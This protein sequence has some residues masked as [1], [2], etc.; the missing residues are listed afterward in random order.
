VYFDEKIAIMNDI[1]VMKILKIFF[2]ISYGFC[3]IELMLFVLAFFGG[4]EAILEA[5]EARI[6]EGRG[7]VYISS[8]YS[9]LS[10]VLSFLTMATPVLYL[11]SLLLCLMLPFFKC[12][13]SKLRYIVGIACQVIIIFLTVLTLL[14]FS[15]LT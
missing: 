4:A 6:P 5:I 14:L 3:L 8:E 12:M 13:R 11:T 10:K 15:V 9:T 1:V 2:W 7:V